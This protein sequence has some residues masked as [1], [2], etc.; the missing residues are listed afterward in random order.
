M[1]D[2]KVIIINGNPRK[3]IVEKKILEYL[4]DVPHFQETVQNVLTS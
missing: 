1:Y 2:P 3:Q 4:E